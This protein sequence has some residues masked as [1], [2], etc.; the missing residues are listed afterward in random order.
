MYKNKSIAL[1]IPF[2]NEERLIGKTIEKIPDF[3]D[4]IYLIDDFSTDNSVSII[5]QYQE[6]NNKIFLLAHGKKLGPGAAVIT[7][8]VQSK[9]DNNDI[10]VVC[11]GDDQMPMEQIE[12][13][14]DPLIHN[15][16]DYTKGNRFLEGGGAFERMPKIRL[17]ANTIISLMT[18]ISSGCYK[19]FD[20]VDGFTAINARA[21]RMIDWS[22]AWEGYG[23]PMDFLMRLNAYG[24]RVK[25]VPRRAIYLEGE[26]QSQIKGFSY[27]VKVSPM[28]CRNFFWRLQKRYIFRDFHPLV[29]LYFFGFIFLF[30]G[31]W[32][33]VYLIK[34][35]LSGHHPTGATAIFCAL[36]ITIS[37]QCLFFAMLFDMMEEHS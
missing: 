29:F 10:T 21:L 26:R 30:V 11:G 6:K 5:S 31:L 8:Y 19:I 35:S 24:L 37:I 14:I 2:H 7:G 17:F 15:Q 27:A 12:Q 4:N 1:V 36:L 28:L 22:R 3:V 23:Y 16:A 33:G 9:K 32:V 34:S 25:D 13:L 18:K 20:V